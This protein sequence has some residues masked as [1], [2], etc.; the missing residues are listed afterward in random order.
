MSF[1]YVREN[2]DL[3]LLPAIRRRLFDEARHDDG[4]GAYWALLMRADGLPRIETSAPA[5]PKPAPEQVMFATDMA[6]AL[7]KHLHHDGAWLVVFTHPPAVS[8]LDMFVTYGRFALV[9]IDRD[10]DPQFSI[11]CDDDFTEVL[12]SGLDHWMEE[13]ERGWSK[14]SHHMTKVFDKKLRERI[15]YKRAQGEQAPSNVRH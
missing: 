2:A 14:W 7:N 13:C 12:L 9:W 10:A 1:S 4:P 3:L 6:T 8:V 11:D 5:L 15:T